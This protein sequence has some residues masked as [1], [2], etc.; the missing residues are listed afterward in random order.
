MSDE[1]PSGLGPGGLG[2][3]ALLSGRAEVSP[4]LTLHLSDRDGPGLAD[5]LRQ[6]YYWIVNN[7]VIVP[8]YDVAFA[9]EE[10][11][12]FDFPNGDAFVLP[13]GPAWSSYVL[14][15]LLTF[16]AGR[17]ALLVG[18]PGRG[19]TATA[20][21]MGLLAGYAEAEVQRAVQHGHPQLT[22]ADL[23]G[24]PMPSDL[25]A[26]RTMDEIRIAW[27]RW[28]TMRVKI[29]DEYNRIPTRTQSAL[30]SLMAEGYAEMLGQ[31]VEAGQ[32][33]WFLTANDDTG[34]GTFQVIEA[35]KDRIDITIRAMTFN[36]RFL[37]KLLE[38]LEA[39]SNPANVV[40]ADI[41]FSEAEMDRMRAAIRAVPFETSALRRLE[42]FVG[43]LDFCQRASADFEAKSKDT[44]KLA[45]V[46]LHSV[47]NEDCPLDKH[48]HVCSQT[49]EGLSVRSY[50]TVM[51]F[52][53][54]IAFFRGAE[55]VTAEDVRQVLPFVLHEKLSANRR[56]DFFTD[57][58][59]QIY[60]RDKVAWIRQMWDRAMAQYDRA[61]RE[62]NDAG[63]ALLAELDAGLEG[64]G[65]S[66]VE[67]RLRNVER[68]IADLCQGGE[69]S[70]AVYEDLVRLKYIYLRYQNYLRWLTRAEDA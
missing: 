2:F 41:I 64:V 35:L 55:A 48:E 8:Y 65:R 67:K 31:T 16:A 53:K 6:A 12:R 11:R 22:I 19:K 27:R 46:A 59:H 62:Q 10:G 18:G 5:K 20:L 70:A 39:D 7:A 56:G 17:R 42:F 14:F 15:P 50:L 29:I 4:S 40:P 69:L 61:D 24:N 36:S 52:A 68:A 25:M 44:L 43:S 32:G 51:T 26:A 60:L 23:L 66:E 37:P 63:R 28:I 49:V 9:A 21:L 57:D 38:R 54:A 47:C 45:G 3:A 34:G 13:A 30:L 58:R 1:T 33:A